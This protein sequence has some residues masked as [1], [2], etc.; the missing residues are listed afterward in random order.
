MTRRQLDALARALEAVQNTCNVRDRLAVDP[1]GVVRRYEHPEA[2]ELVGLLAASLAFG[3]VKALRGA[4]EQV[5]ERLGPEL[6]SALEDRAATLRR[7]AGFKYRMVHG[8]DIGRLL[9]GA[10]RVQVLHGSL[11]DAF[12]TDLAEQGSL[13]PALVE[14]TGRIREHAGF[15]GRADEGR[16]GPQHVMSDP[17]GTSGCKRLMLY[18]R[19]MVRPDDGVDLG[20]WKGV[21]PS[22]LLMPVDT[23]VHRIAK[24]LG[25]TRRREPSWLASEEITAILR[26]IDPVDPVRFDF[27]LCHLGM[28]GGCPAKPDA[29][30]CAGCAARRVCN[31]TSPS[32]RPGLSA[33]PRRT[34]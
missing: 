34:A 2:R 33:G 6:S 27:A 8:R 20:L 29:R 19:W 3:N 17:S 30:M 22:V 4:I 21:S 15:G 26:Q 12:A 9:V 25:L 16:R 14:W 23:H 31:A 5:I 28:T 32:I 13:R 18:L 7:L 24:N 10:R 11:G 1:V